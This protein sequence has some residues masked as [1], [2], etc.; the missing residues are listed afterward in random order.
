MQLDNA[1]NEN[2]YIDGGRLD[3]AFI[4][5]IWQN[6]ITTLVTCLKTEI[7]LGRAIWLLRRAK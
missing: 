2:G 7:L 5:A 6:C 4:G 3:H 1:F